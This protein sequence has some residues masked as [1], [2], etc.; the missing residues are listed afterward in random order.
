MENSKIE[1][2][3]HTF[4]PWIG[5]HKVSPGCMNCYASTFNNRFKKAEWVLGGQRHRTSDSYQKSPLKWNKEARKIN[6]IHRVFCASLADVFE[7]NE[8]DEM[9]Q[10]REE[11]HRDLIT[12][13]PYLDWLLLTKR[14]ENISKFYGS[15]RIPWNIWLGTSVENQEY[16]EKRIPELI[17]NDSPVRFLSCEPLLGPLDLSPW[18]KYID[19]V[20]V[21][22]ESGPGARPMNK[23]WVISL[24]NQC[25]EAGLPFFFKQW[26][27][28]KNHGGR[29][30]EGRTWN[31]LPVPRRHSKWRANEELL[32]A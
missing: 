32:V 13:T 2:T 3:H 4:N 27:S 26:G 16:A 1:W 22:G 29:L 19:W 18:L 15:R 28:S 11:L 7:T 9:A 20:I 23:E 5:C 25:L 12:K 14:P 10:W 30:L 8:H 6:Q 31:E 21:G 24:R 17:K